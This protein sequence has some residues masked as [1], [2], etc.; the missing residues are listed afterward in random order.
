[1]LCRVNE[2]AVEIRSTNEIK[3][4]NLITLKYH[5]NKQYIHLSNCKP[6]LSSFFP[7]FSR[8]Y[9][10]RC[11]AVEKYLFVYPHFQQPGGDSRRRE[12]EKSNTMRM[13]DKVKEHS[14]YLSCKDENNRDSFFCC[15]CCFCL[16]C[17]SS[18]VSLL[19]NVMILSILLSLVYVSLVFLCKQLLISIIIPEMKKKTFD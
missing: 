3:K 11:C 18:S 2:S 10:K 9:T 15:C 16:C 17:F 4:K 13:A 19:Y 5:N 7:F 1:M 8:K 12:S 14:K 6:A